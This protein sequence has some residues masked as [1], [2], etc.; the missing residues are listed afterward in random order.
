LN[1]HCGCANRRAAWLRY[2]L[3]ASLQFALIPC[4]FGA[5]GGTSDSVRADQSRMMATI[6]STDTRN[7]TIHEMTTPTGVVVREYVSSAGQVFG[8]AWQGP[9]MPDM[10]QILGSYFHQFSRAVKAKRESRPNRSLLLI[11][12]PGIVVESNGHMRAYSGRAY[13][14]RLLP[15]GVHEH[16]VR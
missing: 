6:H 12:E 16:E 13:D 11:R 7:Y 3:L 14:P 10:R 2:A 1:Q 15:E 4:T 9:F 5:L 8:V